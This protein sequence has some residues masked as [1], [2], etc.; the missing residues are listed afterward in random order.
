M[1]VKDALVLAAGAAS[2]TGAMFGG[3][4]LLGELPWAH[5]DDVST[6]VC[7]RLQTQNPLGNNTFHGVGARRDCPTP[8]RSLIS[9]LFL[10]APQAQ[11]CVEPA[12]VFAALATPTG[13]TVGRVTLRGA[14]MAAMD[15]TRAA[16]ARQH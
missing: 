2:A 6:E 11:L 13:M 5:A 15:A 8:G 12:A 16:E 14:M 1:K 4:A 3:M 9:F 10:D 7:Q